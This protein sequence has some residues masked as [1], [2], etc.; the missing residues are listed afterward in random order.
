MAG[1]ESVG[2][3]ALGWVASPVVKELI[4]KGISYL[5]SDMAEELDDLETIYLPQFQLT[6]RGAQNST[7]KDNLDTLAKWLA[8][9]KNAYYDAEAILHD[10]EYE[11]LKRRAKGDDRKKQWVRI[12]SHLI[13]KPLK[14]ITKKVNLKVSL[15]SPQKKKLLAQ[16][17]KLKKINCSGSK[18]IP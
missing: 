2:L 13:I 10:L 11:R 12:S 17:K 1:P 4:S 7:D 15:L 9:L 6:I 3:A 14:T 8:R 18:G 16:L 5:G